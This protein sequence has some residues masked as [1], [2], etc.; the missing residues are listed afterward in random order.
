MMFSLLV[1]NLFVPYIV[2]VMVDGAGHDIEYS[3]SI[4]LVKEESQCRPD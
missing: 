1:F 3:V 4:V 2:A